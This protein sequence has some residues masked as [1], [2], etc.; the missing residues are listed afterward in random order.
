MVR[1]PGGGALTGLDGL[2]GTLGRD[3]LRPL[4]PLDDREVTAVVLV[5][6]DDGVEIPVGALVGAAG[7]AAG[8]PRLPDLLLRGGAAG[9]AAVVVKVR[10]AA[11]SALAGAAELAAQAG[12]VLLA[13]PDDLPWLHLVG[14]VGTARQ[15]ANDTASTT[16]LGDR[17]GLATAGAA[18]AGGAT[19]VEDPDRR[20]LAYSTLPGQDI[21]EARQLGIL[22]RQVPYYPSNDFDYRRLY[23]SA[24]VVRLEP[25]G[26]TLGRLA[27]AVRSG[28]ELLGS[29]W[30]VDAGDLSADAEAVLTD[31]S[32]LAALHLLRARS[33]EDVERRVRGDSLR[34]LLDERLSPGVAAERLGYPP[35]LLCQLLVVALPRGAAAVDE[36]ILERLHEL[37]ALRCAGLSTASVTT[38]A[39]ASV[40]ALLADPAEGVADTLVQGLLARSVSALGVQPR[41]AVGEPAQLLADAP[42]AR[43]ELDDILRLLE[44]PGETRTVAS[45][46]SVHAALVLLR[47]HRQLVAQPTLVLAA[48]AAMVEFDRSQAGRYVET[49]LAYL[50]CFGDVAAA[51]ARVSI[52]ANTFRY[53]LRRVRELFDLDLDDPDTRL[54]LWLQ[55]KVALT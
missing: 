14:L 52:H 1:P 25:G 16:A 19:A 49:V 29:I 6:A 27:V 15:H 31:A 45:R 12:V 2:A 5:E 46:S 8:D 54:V 30:V 37:V 21:D 55:L 41:I 18:A 28:S 22:G 43:R 9:A 20:I 39:G 51:S 53:R 40:W 36:L 34:S 44:R 3:V 11:E 23:R 24:G 10:D 4:H 47:V 35:D 13:A 48:V 26:T 17:F 38:V 7:L 33:R 50:D 42:A 32:R